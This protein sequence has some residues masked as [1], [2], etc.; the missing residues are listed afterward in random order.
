LRELLKS[1]A[2]K[3]LNSSEALSK[4]FDYGDKDE[5]DIIRCIS[6]TDSKAEYGYIYY[7]NKTRNEAILNETCVFNKLENYEIMHHHPNKI[8]NKG[9]N[10]KVSVVVPPGKSEIV[11]LKRTERASSYSVT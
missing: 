6:I 4:K 3:N 9:L 10:N 8:G 2:R 1:C 11:V 7:E 5:P